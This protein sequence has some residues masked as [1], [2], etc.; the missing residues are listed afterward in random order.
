MKALSCF[1]LL[2]VGF[3]VGCGGNQAPT[4][5]EEEDAAYQEQYEADYEAQAQ[6]ARD[7]AKKGAGK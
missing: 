2:M 5:T 4:M 3:L 7:A 1:S 6:A